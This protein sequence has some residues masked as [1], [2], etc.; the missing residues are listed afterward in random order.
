VTWNVGTLAVG[1]GAQLMLTAQA[2]TTGANLQNTAVASANTP[3]PNPNDN[4]VSVSVNVAVLT[5]PQLS[6]GALAGNGTFS[7]NITGSPV[8]TIIQGA[9][10]LVAPVWISI[11]TNTPPFVFTDPNAASY[12]YR[13]YR[14][15]TAQ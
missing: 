2:N 15:V 6:G 1:G 9:T 3:D 8:L 12:P 10:N 13:F 11:V 14:A 4:T 7:M 5:P